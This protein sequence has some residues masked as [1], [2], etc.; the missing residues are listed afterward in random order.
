MKTQPETTDEFATVAEDEEAPLLEV[1]EMSMDDVMLLWD[2]ESESFNEELRNRPETS[3]Y[4]YWQKKV[5]EQRREQEEAAKRAQ[6]ASRED[7]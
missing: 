5:A 6:A 4:G 1:S 3:C 7:H 2:G